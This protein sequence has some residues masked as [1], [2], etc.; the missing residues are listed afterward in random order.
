MD[1]HNTIAV[2]VGIITILGSVY[3]L[4]IEPS[5]DTKIASLETKG[6]LII[7]NL[8]DKVS[9]RITTIDR[10]ID[11]HLQ[12]YINYKDAILL[13]NNGLDGKINHTWFKTKELLDSLKTEIKEIKQTLQK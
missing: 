7:D 6:F 8:K 1:I 4:V 12:D 9:E 10:K 13:Q 3:K 2:I 5:I 11:I